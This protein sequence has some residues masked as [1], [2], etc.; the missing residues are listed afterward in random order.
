MVFSS[1]VFA[2]QVEQSLIPQVKKI[3]ID[4][5]KSESN[6][7]DAYKRI[8][9]IAS[10]AIDFHQGNETRELQELFTEIENEVSFDYL[11]LSKE[12]MV[13]LI[14]KAINS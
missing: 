7:K 11:K 8:Q 9:Q 13:T 3:I 6:A 2:N 4:H 5:A 1:S 10:D 12:Q 14:I